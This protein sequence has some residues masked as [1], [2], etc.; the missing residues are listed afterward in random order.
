MRLISMA[1]TG[2]NQPPILARSRGDVGYISP[3]IFDKGGGG[4]ICNHPPNVVK[5]LQYF[6]LSLQIWSKSTDFA[7]KRL[8]F[9]D[10]SKIYQQF[11]PNYKIL[12][13]QAH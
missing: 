7:L 5:S 1:I 2:T 9:N 4:G 12:V 13:S 6:V 11:P 8:I 10:S 3:P